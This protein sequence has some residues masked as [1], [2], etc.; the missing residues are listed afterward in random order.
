MWGSLWRALFRFL[1]ARFSCSCRP[2]LLVLFHPSHCR[3]VFPHCLSEDR[4]SRVCASIEARHAA[5]VAGRAGAPLEYAVPTV[6]TVRFVPHAGEAPAAD[7]Q[8]AVC[9]DTQTSPRLPVVSCSCAPLGH[10]PHCSSDYASRTRPASGSPSPLQRLPQREALVTEAARAP[11]TAFRVDT[12]HVTQTTTTVAGFHRLQH[13]GTVP[14]PPLQSPAA[15]SEGEQASSA[16]PKQ[17]EADADVEYPRLVPFEYVS[18][19]RRSLT[20]HLSAFSK[21]SELGGVGQRP[22]F[23]RRY[24]CGGP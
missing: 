24:P 10:L 17:S 13:A 6:E 15:A 8:A 2:A 22:L 14:A 7:R 20:R 19:D 4:W 1:S 3:R 21:G 16:R 5:N 11:A 23:W 12:A 9:S 18:R